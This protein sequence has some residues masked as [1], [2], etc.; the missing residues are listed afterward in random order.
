[1]CDASYSNSRSGSEQHRPSQP[2]ET[3]RGQRALVSK[4]LNLKHS[5]DSLFSGVAE[6]GG[7]GSQGEGR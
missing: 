5:S 6:G 2:R 1:M 4:E 7:E 3:R